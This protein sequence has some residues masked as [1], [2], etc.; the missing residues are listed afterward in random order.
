MDIPESAKKIIVNVRENKKVAVTFLGPHMSK[1]ELIQVLRAIRLEYRH[2]VV[3]YRRN[4]TLEVQK[5]RI[6]AE[7]KTRTEDLGES[8]N[9]TI[10]RP[11]QSVQ[12]RA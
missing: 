6:E 11:E 2:R 12:A 7:A 10:T 1:R 5:R 9:D 3:L 8:S 4:I